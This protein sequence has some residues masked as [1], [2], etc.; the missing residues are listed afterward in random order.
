MIVP[1]RAVICFIFLSFLSGAFEHLPRSPQNVGQGA[2]ALNFNGGIPGTYVD[3]ASLPAGRSGGFAF[4]GGY[5]FGLRAL[6]HWSGIS[7][8]HT[9]LAPIGIGITS[10]GNPAY[11]ETTVGLYSGYSWGERIRW[12]VE[13]NLY[14]LSIRDYGSDAV[15]G[16]TVAWHVRLFPQVEWGTILRNVNTPGIGLNADPLPQNIISGFLIEIQPNLN[17]QLEWE[18]D[19]AYKGEM[20]YG[21]FYQFRPWLSLT[22]GFCNRTGQFTAAMNFQI[23]HLSISYAIV[24]HP[25]LGNSQWVGIAVPLVKP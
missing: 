4:Q 18:Q 15:V 19:T 1:K 23:S 20:K 13:A 16:F 11:S 25:Q 9:R 2:A 12:G 7:V 5:Q 3:P 6:K 22:S 24:T 14:T 10:F 21:V 17:V 8:F